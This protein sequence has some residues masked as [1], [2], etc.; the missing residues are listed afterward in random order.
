[1]LGSL[2]FSFYLAEELRIKFLV[3][4]EGILFYV[5]SERISATVLVSVLLMVFLEDLMPGLELD[6]LEAGRY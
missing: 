2:P 6:L 4:R 5:Y 1:M 3:W